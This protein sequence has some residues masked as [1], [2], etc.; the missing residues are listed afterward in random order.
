MPSCKQHETSS[1]KTDEIPIERILALTAGSP[2]YIQIL[3]DRLVKY[4]NRKRLLLVAEADV[5]QVKQDLIEGANSEL[6]EV[7]RP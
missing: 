2:F 7:V 1:Q 5:E 3:C 6:L 4:M